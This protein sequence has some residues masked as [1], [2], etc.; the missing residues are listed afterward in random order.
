MSD[1]HAPAYSTR[2]A[3]ASDR[4]QIQRLL[5]KFEQEAPWRSRGWHSL[6][7]GFLLVLGISLSFLLG[8]K[9][10]QGIVGLATCGITFSF[11]KIVV[12]QEWKKFWVIEQEG[13]IVAC[14]KLCR[15]G[16]HSVLYDVLVLPQYRRQ[17]M[18]SALV[19]H[20]TQQASKPLYLACCPDKIG[21]YTQLG[22]THTRSSELSFILRYE[23]GIS[24]CPD[25]V[26][27]VLR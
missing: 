20:L 4:W 25:V 27:L 5:N 3:I 15:Y 26:P 6:T 17:G 23:L 24:I 7:L 11:I 10:L 8:L 21:F 19:K 12:S 13:R 1:L 16:T 22:F 9:F 2:P 14:G 18:G